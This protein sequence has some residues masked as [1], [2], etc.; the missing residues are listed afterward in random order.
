MPEQ[1]AGP[2]IY[3]MGETMPIALEAKPSLAGIQREWDAAQQ[4]WWQAI[5]ERDD[6]R[7]DLCGVDISIPNP[8]APTEEP[9][10]SAWRHANHICRSKHD[11]IRGGKVPFWWRGEWHPVLLLTSLIRFDVWLDER[12]RTALTLQENTPE[13]AASKLAFL[14]QTI[15]NAETTLHELGEH[16][17]RSSDVVDSPQA[18][19]L[20]I[21]QLLAREEKPK[22]PE[23]L[24]PKQYLEG[25][26][27][28]AAATEL[29]VKRS[30]LVDWGKRVRRL[31]EKTAGP[32]KSPGRGGKVRVE[33]TEFL[34]WWNTVEHIDNEKRQR[35]VD[36][37]AIEIEK[38]THRFGTNGLQV[39]PSISGSIK[40][41]RTT[42]K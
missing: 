37:S 16:G 18:G 34:N 14:Q 5:H 39:V 6:A 7:R 11:R 13:L 32:I 9:A 17:W 8:K 2:S 24:I 40:K 19:M 42:K 35:R 25:W 33:K 23:P 4:A 21:E 29:V 15:A 12:R 26:S 3:R 22:L 38:N 41:R 31:S 36:V 30:G 1:R 20:R 28:I 27:E 10:A